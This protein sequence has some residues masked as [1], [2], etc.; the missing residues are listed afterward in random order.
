MPYIED[1]IVHDADAHTMETPEWLEP[2]SDPD[3]R[4]AIQVEFDKAFSVLEVR[5]LI[6]SL[7]GRTMLHSV[8]VMKES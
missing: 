8:Q 3:M 2:F 1:R 5:R 7:I 6:R 4:D